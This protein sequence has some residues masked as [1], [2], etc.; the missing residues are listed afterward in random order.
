MQASWRGE[1]VNSGGLTVAPYSS[2]SF[3]HSRLPAAQASH[4]GVLPSMLRASTWRTQSHHKVKNTTIRQSW[5]DEE[6]YQLGL[7]LMWSLSVVAHHWHHLTCAPAFSSSLTHWVCPCIH[8]SCRGVMESTAT[9]LTGAP[10]SIS[11][12]SW[13]ALPWAAASCTTDRSVQ[14]PRPWAANMWSQTKLSLSIHDGYVV[15][16]S[17][18]WLVINKVNFILSFQPYKYSWNVVVSPQPQSRE[19]ERQQAFLTSL[20]K[21]WD[22]SIETKKEICF[23]P[24][25]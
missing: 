1:K 25:D 18:C 20:H 12:C 4:S 17:V 14:N 13:R 11:F 22:K 6:S 19:K 7:S 23:S 15:W 3:T 16:V 5:P 24:H 9:M 2:S 8:A 21:T 10:A